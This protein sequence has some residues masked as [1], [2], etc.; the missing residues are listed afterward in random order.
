MQQNQTDYMA[1]ST[2]LAVLTEIVSGLARTD[3]DHVTPIQGLSLHRRNH[4]T[5]PLHCV[6]SLSL[7]LTLQG[8]KQVLMGENLFSVLPGQ[9][10]ITTIDLPVISH[11][12][13]A[14]RHS[15]YLGVLLKLDTAKILELNATLEL[16]K[17]L[18]SANYQS[19]S[20]EQ[21]DARLCDAMIRLLQLPLQSDIQP[22]LQSILLQEIILLLLIGPH[23]PHLRQ[24]VTEGSPGAQISKA[25]AWL[26][27]NFSLSLNM[28]E[29][30][31]KAHMSASSFRQHFRA[32]TGT[33]PLQY[34][35]QLRLQEARELMLNQDV[36]ASRASALVG[37]ESASQF[38]REYS[39][40][41][42][43]PPQ[44]DIRKLR[45]SL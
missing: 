24:L 29:L 3:G 42:G 33:S 39:R 32:I 28:N 25:V 43:L 8:S 4:P 36:D 14:S 13:E 41:Y 30:A 20:I 17:P 31:D 23:G 45:Q 1:L 44:Q 26:K 16:N 18:R 7:A 12:K 21:A 15:P 5:E 10:M 37:Y 9:T 35:K 2:K 6:Y 22:Q 11:V 19:V 40:M 27:Q 34:Q 38:S